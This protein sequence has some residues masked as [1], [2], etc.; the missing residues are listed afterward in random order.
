VDVLIR[1]L[2]DT[3]RT[4]P[5]DEIDRIVERIATAPFNSH[6]VRVPSDERGVS[7]RGH[8]LGTRADSPIY[9]LVKRVVIEQ[10]WAFGTT[11]AEYL[12]DLRRAVRDP[13]AHLAVYA[14]RADY[15]AV[16]VTE[17]S[18]I[19]PVDRLGAKPQRLCFVVYSAGHGIIKTGYLIS[20][21]GT[22][23]IPKRARWLK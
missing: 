4:P 22:A 19:L 1:E 11:L 15:F 7:Y 21:P 5:P 23:D 6:S 16:A 18:R 20:G 12:A 8:T 13:S 17:T 14:D 3:G 2:V 9:H 10:Q